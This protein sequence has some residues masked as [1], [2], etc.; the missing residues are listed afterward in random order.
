[1][2]LAEPEK[3][4]GKTIENGD[5][6]LVDSEALNYKNGDIVVA[7]IDGM[8]TIKRYMEDAENNRVVLKADST[9]KYLPIFIHG[10]DDFQLSGKVVG[11]I[12]S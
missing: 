5:Y 6:V 10:D 7:I 11:V 4:S 12:K 8:A 1:M 3:G 9:E 2:N